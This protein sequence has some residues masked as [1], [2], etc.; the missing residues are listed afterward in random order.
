MLAQPEYSK[1]PLQPPAKSYV[2][3]GSPTASETQEKKNSSV[4]L[5]QGQTLSGQ[6][7]EAYELAFQQL[8]IGTD[9]NDAVV[10]RIDSKP[11][12]RLIGFADLSGFSVQ[13]NF[14]Q[15][16]ESQITSSVH[17][18]NPVFSTAVTSGISLIASALP[19]KP[20]MRDLPDWFEQMT[21]RIRRLP[22]LQSNWDTY[23]G[24]TISQSTATRALAVASQLATALLWLSPIKAFAS[25]THSGGVL[26]EV[27]NGN[28][29]LLLEIIPYES[30][31]ELSRITTLASGEEELNE[32][33]VNESHLPEVLN[34]IAG[35][36]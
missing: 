29:E 19:V 31:Y 12:L 34:W 7:H 10:L 13:T 15:R 24:R 23:G 22:A 32:S 35:N 2:W 8:N 3:D 28:R 6:T 18:S 21:A 9:F 14:K 33:N 5:L 36:G 30:E 4:V 25:P 1:L 17:M 26:F 20:V 27:R 11:G 16:G